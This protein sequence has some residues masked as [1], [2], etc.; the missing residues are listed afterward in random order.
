MRIR[1]LASILSVSMTAS[2]LPATPASAGGLKKQPETAAL[3][4]V[5]KRF[6]KLNLT[7]EQKSQIHQF[8]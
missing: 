3:L 6:E 8:M 1:T 2:L 4:R 5:P 7:D